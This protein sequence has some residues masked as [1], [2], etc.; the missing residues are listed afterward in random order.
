MTPFEL[1]EPRSLQDAL[2]LL[3]TDDPSVRA[4]GGCT[5]LMLM[6]KTG[7]F[8]PTCLVSRRRAAACRHPV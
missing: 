4:F 5:A 1:A 6:M 2:A 7:V 3:N 8:Q